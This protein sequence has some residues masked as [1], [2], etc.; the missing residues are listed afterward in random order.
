MKSFF[1]LIAV[2]ALLLIYSCSGSVSGIKDIIKPVTV[3]AGVADSVLVSDLFFSDEYK[4]K[5]SGNENV[6]VSYNPRNE[7]LYLTPRPDF[8]GLTLVDF[9]FGGAKY[10]IPVYSKVQNKFKFTFRPEKSYKKITLIGSFNGWDRGSLQM[11]DSDGDGIY[12][13]EIP[14]EPGRYEYKFYA[15]GEEIVDPR[16]PETKPNG[17]G[18]FNSLFTVPEPDNGKIFLHIDKYEKTGS[19]ISV[20]YYYENEKSPDGI[21]YGSLIPLFNNIRIPEDQIKI[22]GGRIIINLNDNQLKGENTLRLAVNKNGTVTNLQSALIIDGKPAGKDNKN[23]TWYDGIIYS[24][25]TDRFYDG[26]TSNDKPVVRDSLFPKANY[27][28]GDFKGISEKIIEGYFDSL[29]VNTLWISP[30]YDNPDSAYREYPA[31][32]RWY[33]GYHGYWPI[34]AYGVEEKFGTI[35][36]LKKLISNAH[37]HNMKVLLDFV[38]HHVHK[39]HPYF[40]EHPEWFGK[41]ELPDGRKNLRLWDEYRLTTWFEPYMPSFDFVD[42]KEARDTVSANAVWWLKTTGAD[43]FRHDAVKHVPNEF[44]RELTR[45]IKKEIDPGRRLGVYQIGETFGSYDLVSSY[46]NNGQLSAQFN[47]NLYDTGLPVF[48]ENLS[49]AVLDAE[50]KKSFL[51]YGVNNQ[52]GNIMDSHDKTRFMAYADGDLEINQSDA[53]EIGWSNPPKVDDPAN[54]KKAEL[55]YA[56]MNT[57]PGLP[58]IYY[59]SEFGMTGAA[60]PDNRRMMR[61]GNQLSAGEENMLSAVRKIIHI[62]KNHPA[63]R[64]GDFLTLKADENVYAFVRSDLNERILVVLNKS[65]KPQDVTLVLPEFY[66]A[67]SFIDLETGEEFSASAP[68]SVSSTGRRIL[69]VK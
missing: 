27:M 56:Y 39:D 49:F 65:D 55:F 30:V 50:M 69:L 14:L 15:D 36:D 12:D 24:L 38:S 41:L 3:T 9:E 28:G 10:S 4:I 54:Y 11:T 67:K 58:V 17:M 13:I 57:I 35:D 31:P 48:L 68:L 40:K 18:S 52:M 59:G 45:K 43:G 20:S 61:F 51:V 53:G 62:R 6:S 26:D 60:D 63:L 25:M 34:S 47:F 2:P 33:T 32:H 22:S 37:A 46:V 1:R 44:W 64:Y 8:S 5:F 16:N 21:D 19:G 7:M 66:S 42:S 29:G 23:F